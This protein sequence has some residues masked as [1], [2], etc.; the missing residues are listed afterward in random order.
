MKS[1]PVYSLHISFWLLKNGLEFTLF[2]FSY[3][4]KEP[5]LIFWRN[6]LLIWAIYAVYFYLNYSVFIPHYLSARRYVLYLT[7][8]L[9]STLIFMAAVCLIWNGYQIQ[10]LWKAA[11]LY[12]HIAFNAAM[13]F[14]GSTAMRMLEQWMESERRG[15]LLAQEVREA[16]LAYLKSQM[17]PHFLFNTLN[18][19]YGLAINRSERTSFAIAQLKR[20]MLYVQNFKE[21]TLID[22]REE[23]RTLESF[24]ALNALRYDCK[25]NFTAHVSRDKVVE[26]M[27]FLPFIENAFKH[28]DTRAG[29]EIHIAV[30][31]R[32][33]A[34]LFSLQNAIDRNKRKDSIGGIGI[35]NIRRRLDLLYAAQWSMETS[36]D[37]RR[38]SVKLKIDRI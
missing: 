7:S 2:S 16:E 19:I 23:I 34:V 17:S 10:S 4:L 28:G 25:V 22:L 14:F 33:D 38:Y 37:D 8:F 9:S 3:F 29:A 36:L 12:P 15:Q 18:N 24:I 13:L 1:K 32:E 6:T 35:Q 21:G 20:M 26:P 31:A 5:P 27:I 11:S 30:E